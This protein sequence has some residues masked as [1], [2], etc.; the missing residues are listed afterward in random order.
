[1]GTSL[2]ADKKGFSFF[3][4][5]FSSSKHLDLTLVGVNETFLVTL[6]L[7]YTPLLHSQ[8]HGYSLFKYS[9]LRAAILGS[10]LD[11]RFWLPL[12]DLWLVALHQRAVPDTLLDLLPSSLQSYQ[13][14]DHSPKVLI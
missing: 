13:E 6:W 1:M 9:R 12:I 3:E 10:W 11:R 2:A 8:S 4:F 5:Y 14:T 7:A